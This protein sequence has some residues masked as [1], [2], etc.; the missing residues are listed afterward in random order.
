[1]SIRTV[2]FYIGP[3]HTLCVHMYVRTLYQQRPAQAPG[4]G[5]CAEPGELVGFCAFSLVENGG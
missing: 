4:K 5:K 1:M 2:F 3:V